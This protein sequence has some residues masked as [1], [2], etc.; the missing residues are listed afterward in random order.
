M[1]PDTDCGHLLRAYVRAWPAWLGGEADGKARGFKYHTQS[2]RSGDL[3]Y[4]VRVGPY[5]D[6]PSATAAIRVLER[7]QG[8]APRILVETPEPEEEP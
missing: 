6:L 4:E 3:I 2:Q 7:S 8:L 1:R 5:E